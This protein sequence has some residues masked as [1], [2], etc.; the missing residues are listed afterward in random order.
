M[1]NPFV[2]TGGWEFF[3]TYENTKG[4]ANSEANDRTATQWSFESIYRF[5]KDERYYLGGRYNTVSAEEANGDNI[6]INRF[7]LAAGWFWTKNVLA[8]LE[9]VNQNYNGFNTGS[10]FNDG[11]FKGIMFETVISF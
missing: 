4:R 10:Q 3:G 2:K 9:Y 6:D 1:I 7:S 8:K 11:N 5:G